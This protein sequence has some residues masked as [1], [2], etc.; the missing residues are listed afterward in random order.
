MFYFIFYFNLTFHSLIFPLAYIAFSGIFINPTPFSLFMLF[1][2]LFI[3][4]PFIILR[5]LFFPIFYSVFVSLFFLFLPHLFHIF[6]IYFSVV[7]AFFLVYLSF[8]FFLYLSFL[9]HILYFFANFIALL[10]WFNL[11]C[12]LIHACMEML[13]SRFIIKFVFSI[14]F[15]WNILS[16][17][18]YF[19]FIPVCLYCR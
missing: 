4:L 19:N 14:K 16:K 12:L 15:W 8:N 10:F 3:L 5:L 6:S 1:I 11:L 7:T 9:F 13:S 2:Y 17:Q 18:N